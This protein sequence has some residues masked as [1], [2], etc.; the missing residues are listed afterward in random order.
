MLNYERALH[1]LAVKGVQ[2]W[3]KP[4]NIIFQTWMAFGTIHR[5]LF[6]ETK[7]V[8]FPNDGSLST[9]YNGAFC[10]VGQR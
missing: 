6:T 3:Y 9:N 5:P 10:E 2:N 4:T 1:F 7:N 8:Y